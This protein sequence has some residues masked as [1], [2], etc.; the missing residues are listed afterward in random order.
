MARKNRM[1]YGWY[2]VAFCFLAFFMTTGTQFYIFN[3]FL[4]PLCLKHG[5]SRTDVN[6]ALFSGTFVQI[7]SQV[8]WGSLV[9]RHG[10]RPLMLGG[11]VLSG[12]SFMLLGYADRLWLF[13]ILYGSI[14][15]GNS[16]LGG[17]VASTVVN[18]WFV[19]KRGR[20]LGMATSGISFSGA[21]IPLIAM[22]LL[23]T[24]GLV[25]TTLVIGLVLAAMGPLAWL[26]VRDWP[27]D[28][29]LAPDGDSLSH[30][31]GDVLIESKGRFRDPSWE[32]LWTTTQVVHTSAFWKIGLA[33]G[34]MLMGTVGVMSQLKPRFVDLGFGD[35]T[36]MLLMA[37]TAGIGGVSKYMWG[38]LCDRHDVRRIVAVLGLGN[39]LGLAL[40]TS[41]ENIIIVAMFILVFG[42]SMGGIMAAWPI[43]IGDMYGRRS[44]PAVFRF[45]AIFLAL[46]SLGFIIVGQSHDR[47]G[48]YNA[49]YIIFI[50][51]D[52]ISA[53][54]ILSV[55]RP[56][57][58]QAV[59]ST[60]AIQ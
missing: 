6:L 52:L 36:S 42:C 55:K 30:S 20:A 33:F 15:L 12:L 49:A 25:Y 54:L 4:E 44:F 13:Y 48:S 21:V 18:N 16:A 26:I 32:P 53:G 57:R 14:F 5:W 22:L 58:P 17:V 50:G 27:E 19:K 39:A 35:M 46:Q 7:I 37:V 38:N 43:I 56:V 34:I 10:P 60:A 1:F 31:R 47:F 3:A 24:V 28:Y 11:A 23:Q 45:I 51:L 29:G 59:H 40:A 9:I 2:L 8:F 41:G